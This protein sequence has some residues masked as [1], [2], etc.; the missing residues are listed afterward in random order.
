MFDRWRSCI[1]VVAGVT[2][3]AYLALLGW[4]QTRDVA[5]DGS[6]SGPYQPWQVAALV[7]LLAVLAVV[8]GAHGERAALLTTVTMTV[9]F[10]VAFSIDA[11]TEPPEHND[12][13]WPVGAVL[14]LFGTFFSAGMVSA[15]S[16]RFW[17]A[18]R[19]RRERRLT[20]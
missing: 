8:A 19:A 17:A 4:D 14:V 18:R 5:P 3:V 10:T 11:M 13:L 1:G 2:L 7:L 16:R 15:L 6:T 12:G 20:V 9:V